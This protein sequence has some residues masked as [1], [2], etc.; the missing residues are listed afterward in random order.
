[1]W[2]KL[3]PFDGDECTWW[4]VLQECDSLTKEYESCGHI[5]EREGYRNKPNRY[6]DSCGTGIDTEDAKESFDD[7]KEDD[8][9]RRNDGNGERSDTPE[10]LFCVCG[11]KEVPT[12]AVNATEDSGKGRHEEGMPVLGILMLWGI[13]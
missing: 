11:E 9:K 6:I 5:H 13:C 4:L 12:S 7:E 2:I 1:V 3:G 8:E 10:I